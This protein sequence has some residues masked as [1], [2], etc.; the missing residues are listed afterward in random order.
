MTAGEAEAGLAAV[1]I[2][3][4]WWLFEERQHVDADHLVKADA[5][6]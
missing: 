5:V 4:A 1:D 6:C 2:Y 3:A